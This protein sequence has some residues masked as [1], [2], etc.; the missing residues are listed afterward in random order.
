M[1]FS[2]WV[3]PGYCINHFVALISNFLMFVSP[4]RDDDL[5][6]SRATFFS[7]QSRATILSGQPW[8]YLL[9]RK[10][11]A[12]VFYRQWQG[13]LCDL[14]GTG[15][16]SDIWSARQP[17][18]DVPSTPCDQLPATRLPSQEFLHPHEIC[19]SAAVRGNTHGCESSGVIMS[20]NRTEKINVYNR[21]D[22]EIWINLHFLSFVY[23]ITSHN[24]C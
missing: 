14:H 19:T 23:G 16:E 3:W 24:S 9:H 4:C 15:P 11:G 20:L 8:A 2:C 7:R 10:S 18:R 21:D 13:S 22:D 12:P 6:Q 17:D 1:V 5:W